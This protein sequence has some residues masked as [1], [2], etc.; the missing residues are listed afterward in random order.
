MLESSAFW[1]LGIFI[2][3]VVLAA[4]GLLIFVCSKEK[5]F[6][7]VSGPFVLVGGIGAG[8]FLFVNLVCLFPYDL[9]Y[10]SWEPQ[11]KM[12]RH[13]EFDAS[14]DT[15]RN[16]TGG[17]KITFA[18]GSYAFTNDFRLATVT[19]GRQAKMLCKPEFVSGNVDKVRCKALTGG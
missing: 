4:A 6:T 17:L 19:P 13:V 8:I 5:T 1:L 18:D 11:E 3:F 16:S 14:A 9:R 2:F 15:G 7:S 12:V 10:H